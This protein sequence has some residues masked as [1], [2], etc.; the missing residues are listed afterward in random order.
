[1]QWPDGMQLGELAIQ[2]PNA[3]N[4]VRLESSDLDT[5]ILQPKLTQ[6]TYPGIRIKRPD[7]DALQASRNDPICAG[8]FRVI[9]VG[10]RFKRRV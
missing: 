4:E 7:D 5:S 2:L 1:M 8:D 9:P 6:P 3:R 10:A